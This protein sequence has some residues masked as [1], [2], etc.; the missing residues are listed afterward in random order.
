MNEGSQDK[1]KQLAQD[2]KKAWVSEN[3]GAGTFV[4]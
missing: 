3:K 1:A 2:C 4:S